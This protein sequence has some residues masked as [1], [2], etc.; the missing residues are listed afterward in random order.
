MVRVW[1]P[2]GGPGEGADPRQGQGCCGGKCG[3]E[4]VVSRACRTYDR[5][6]DGEYAQEEVGARLE[7]AE[8]ADEHRHAGR[9]DDLCGVQPVAERGPLARRRGELVRAPAGLGLG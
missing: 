2:G 4:R 6:E 3:K 1:G 7:G 9:R 5:E 8:Q